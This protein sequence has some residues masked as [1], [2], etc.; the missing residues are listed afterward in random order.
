MA[1]RQEVRHLYDELG[2]WEAVGNEL[3]V[4][5]AVAWRYVN[6][7]GWE[8]KNNEIRAKLGLPELITR[9]QAIERDEHG[10]FK[11]RSPS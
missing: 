7:P 3:G 5:K 1:T 4:T 9:R 2:T 6:E 8:P 11:P 10:R